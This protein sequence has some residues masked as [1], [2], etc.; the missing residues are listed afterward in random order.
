M[1]RQTCFPCVI[2]INK[3]SNIYVG[4]KKVKVDPIHAMITLLL[5]QY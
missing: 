3:H 1:Q 4:N 2:I 5:L